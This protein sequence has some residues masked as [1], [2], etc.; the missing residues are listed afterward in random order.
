MKCIFNTPASL[1]SLEVNSGYSV[2]P[3]HRLGDTICS[4]MSKLILFFFVAYNYI[5]MLLFYACVEKNTG[6]DQGRL[7]DDD[8]E[9]VVVPVHVAEGEDE[10]RMTTCR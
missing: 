3:R 1:R 7:K 4:N 2:D 6:N 5:N 8:L 9:G 10:V